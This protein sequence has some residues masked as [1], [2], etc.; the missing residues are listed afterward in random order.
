MSK[1]LKWLLI[2]FST[3]A[4]NWKDISLISSFLLLMDTKDGNLNKPAENSSSAT[5]GPC[6][7]K[8]GP[9][10]WIWGCSS[11]LTHVH[12]CTHRPLASLHLVCH[13][14]CGEAIHRDRLAGQPGWTTGQG[15]QRQRLQL[16]SIGQRQVCHCPVL[17]LEQFDECWVWQCFSQHQLRED[18]LHLRHGHWLWV[19]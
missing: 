16:W 10:F 4:I 8:T 6:G 2:K 13:W 11:L 9:I 19:E 12:L 1:L 7:K 15:I 3:A 17:H 14:F 18:L 5:I